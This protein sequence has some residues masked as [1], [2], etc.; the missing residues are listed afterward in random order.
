MMADSA[1]KKR[2]GIATNFEAAIAIP[3]R[4]KIG[5]VAELVKA[6]AL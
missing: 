5:G 1:A 6:P 2:S 3:S 4:E